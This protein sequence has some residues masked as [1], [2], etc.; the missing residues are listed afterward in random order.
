MSS[1]FMYFDGMVSTYGRLTTPPGQ[2]FFLFGVRGVGKSTW[3]R[4]MF[5]DAAY[6]DLLDERLCSSTPATGRSWR[7]TASRCGPPVASLRR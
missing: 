7:A 1:F 6:V 5:P 2:S 3:A 4:A